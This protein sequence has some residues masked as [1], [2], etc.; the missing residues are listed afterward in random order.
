MKPSPP[1]GVPFSRRQLLKALSASALGASL[2]PRLH[3]RAQATSPPKRIVF[4]F[5]PDGVQPDH[6]WPSAVRSPTDYDL[7]ATSSLNPLMRHRS[8]VALI[9]GLQHRGT[10]YRDD[11]LHD[12][13]MQHLLTGGMDAPAVTVNGLTTPAGIS[14][15]QFLATH[16]GGT[17]PFRSYHLG[18]NAN[19]N[20]EAQRT[21][22]FNARGQGR[23]AVSNPLTVLR[24]LLGG[25][26]SGP[27]FRADNIGN[28]TSVPF[29]ECSPMERNPPGTVVGGNTPPP[30]STDARP[31]RRSVLAALDTDYE[32]L[33]CSLGQEG[34]SKFDAHLEGIRQLERQLGGTS[35][36]PLAGLPVM[37]ACYLELLRYNSNYANYGEWV[38]NASRLQINLLTGALAADATRVALMQYG[39]STSPFE[40]RFMS[41]LPSSHQSTVHHTL[42][43]NQVDAGDA[44]ERSRCRESIRLIAQWHVEQLAYF[45]DSLKQVPEGSGTLFDNTLIVFFSDMY[46]GANHDRFNT[47]VVLAGGGGVGLRRGVALDYTGGGSRPFADLLVTI[48]QA[49][50]LPLSSFGVPSVSNI[51]DGGRQIPGFTG[52]LS[53]L[54]P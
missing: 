15:D 18:I 3:A 43:H 29:S 36:G 50:G 33:R 9:H 40:Y 28:A 2:L 19:F 37:D 26:W 34:R 10:F 14:F 17:T 25:Q 27:S 51:F 21:L 49:L 39:A 13:V 32:R 16:L 53:E 48:G 24:D 11:N 20:N 7:S 52:P 46:W 44:T 41:T 8:D 35:G 1:R 38:D 23:Q 54:F 4:W 42:A 31:W 45:I 6:W 47:P 5:M 22:S 30:P 12:Y